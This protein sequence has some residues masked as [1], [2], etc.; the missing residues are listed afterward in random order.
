MAAAAEEYPGEE[1]QRPRRCPPPALPGSLVG[2]RRRPCRDELR[3]VLLPDFLVKYSS[4]KSYWDK[5][6]DP[7]IKERKALPRY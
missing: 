2:W 6:E 4:R 5:L 7:S 3:H 1:L